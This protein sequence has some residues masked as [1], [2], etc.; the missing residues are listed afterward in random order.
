MFLLSFS[1]YISCLLLLGAFSGASCSHATHTSAQTCDIEVIRRDVCIIGGGSSGTYAAMA[2]RQLNQSVVVVEK[3]GRLGGHTVTYID[4]TTDTPVDFGVTL[5]E[6]S[7]E[8]VDFFTQLDVPVTKVVP[9]RVQT[10]RLDFRT[11]ELVDP[12]PGNITEALGRYAQIL[13]Q[14]PYLAAGWNLPDEVPEDLVMPFSEFVEKYDLG[15][16]IEL[17]SI[18]SQGVRYWLDYPS[19]YMMKFVS[20]AMLNAMQTGFLST[21][22]HNNGEVFEAALAE[23]G[24][25]V[26]LD[27]VVVNASRS[28]DETHWLTVQSAD[29]EITVIEADATILA[30]PPVGPVLEGLDVDEPESLLFEEFIYGHYYAGLV[31]VDGYPDGLQIINRGADTPYT[32]PSLPCT[33][34]IYPTAVPDIVMVSYGSEEPMSEADVKAAI[35]EDILGLGDAGYDVSDPEFLAFADHSPFEMSVSGEAIQAG[36]YD[37]LN[38]LQGYRNTYYVGATFEYPGSSAIWRGVDQLLPSIIEGLARKS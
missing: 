2:L 8:T 5:F 19:V 3:S 21:A 10:V 9:G 15:A 23:L 7:P 30:V 29:G 6:D 11:G 1:M 17:I 26:L 38:A 13:Q 34:M 35:V 14:Y 25:D 4:P 31:R 22:R 20:E 18:Y 12:Y 28:D 32:L 24:E 16:A 27:S 37:Y 33:F 36:F